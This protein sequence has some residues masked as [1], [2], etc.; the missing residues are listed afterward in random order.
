[1]CFRSSPRATRLGR[2]DARWRTGPE[3]TGR[4]DLRAEGTLVIEVDASGAVPRA[5]L[6][7]ADLAGTPLEICLRTVASRWRFPSNGRAYRIDAPVKVSGAGS[8]R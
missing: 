3:A 4:P 2:V 5:E 6:Q 8:R 7:G 1:M